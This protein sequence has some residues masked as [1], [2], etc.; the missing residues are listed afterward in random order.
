MFYQGLLP[1]V[2]VD[3]I[4]LLSTCEKLSKLFCVAVRSITG[5]EVQVASQRVRAA[6]GSQRQSGLVLPP[7]GSAQTAPL[8]RPLPSAGSAGRT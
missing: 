7:A 3:V 2:E 4:V 8:P 1:F 6:G 5:G